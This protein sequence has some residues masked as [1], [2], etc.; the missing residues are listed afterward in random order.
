[1]SS[2]CSLLG[3]HLRERRFVSHVTNRPALDF[4]LDSL[5]GQKVRLS[6]YRGKRVLL[7]FWAFG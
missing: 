3:D 1:M 2:G 5:D 6:D 4:E 7:A